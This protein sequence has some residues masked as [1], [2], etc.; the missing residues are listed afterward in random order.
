LFALGRAVSSTKADRTEA[1]VTAGAP[2]RCSVEA[3]I[4][5]PMA[6]IQVM[7]VPLGPLSVR[8]NVR[9]LR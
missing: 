3:K 4:E 8:V 5:T 6:A 7:P 1:D 9:L 2:L